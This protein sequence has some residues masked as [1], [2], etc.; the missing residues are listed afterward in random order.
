MKA[1]K[2]DRSKINELQRIRRANNPLT[3]ERGRVD[4]KIYRD[5]MKDNVEYKKRKKLYYQKWREKNKDNP[6][7]RKRL[8][9]AAAKHR[10]KNQVWKTAEY[11][12]KRRLRRIKNSVANKIQQREYYHSD[13][14]V[15][16]R[17]KRDY[18]ISIIEY[19]E[20][21]SSQE[22]CCMICGIHKSKLKNRLAVDHCHNSNIIRG[23]LCHT[24]NLV[25]G[26]SRDNIK[27]L[28]SAIKYLNIFYIL[29]A[30]GKRKDKIV[31]NK[32]R[33]IDNYEGKK[34]D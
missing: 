33:A 3:K 9:E 5:K 12:E 7:V 2:E 16:N 31:L 32:K 11:K 18:G 27:I 15:N 6:E 29:S 1:V 21:A 28:E 34:T 10:A 19:N 30:T 20:M 26:N 4:A 14:G 23:L 13:R 17:L 25:I 22:D 24:C 8:N